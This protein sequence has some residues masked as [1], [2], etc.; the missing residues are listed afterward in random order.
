MQ[1]VTV[2]RCGVVV[3]GEKGDSDGNVTPVFFPA[4]HDPLYPDPVFLSLRHQRCLWA[5]AAAGTLCICHD[6][7]DLL[8]TLLNT[9]R[10]VKRR[11]I[12]REWN[13]SDGKVFLSK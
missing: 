4:S 1:S 10:I 3:D 12:G 9:E 5:Y 8:F 11:Q 13:L 6:Y 7:I 2:F